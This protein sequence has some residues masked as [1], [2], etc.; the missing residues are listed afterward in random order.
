VSIRDFGVETGRKGDSRKQEKV[1]LSHVLEATCTRPVSLNRN[2]NLKPNRP[3]TEQVRREGPF[4]NNFY[5]LPPVKSYAK[6]VTSATLSLN[7]MFAYGMYDR[8]TRSVGVVYAALLVKFSYSDR[9]LCSH[10]SQI[11]RL[12]NCG[13]FV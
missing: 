8:H 12:K 1:H 5:T 3:R 2:P 9:N 13:N 11:V 6:A 7:F 4:K 10:C